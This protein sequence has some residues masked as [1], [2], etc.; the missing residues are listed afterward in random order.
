MKSKRSLRPLLWLIKHLSVSY[1]T[2][3]LPLFQDRSDGFLKGTDQ[4]DGKLI[5]SWNNDPKTLPFAL[6]FKTE[7]TNAD[8]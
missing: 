6:E 4:L 3:T 8:N 2:K 1:T 7:G 5:W